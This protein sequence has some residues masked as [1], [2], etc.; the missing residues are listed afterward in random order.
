MVY[1]RVQLAV[2]RTLA[3]QNCLEL[4]S[5]NNMRTI[6]ANRTWYLQQLALAAHKKKGAKAL[7]DALV[8]DETGTQTLMNAEYTIDDSNCYIRYG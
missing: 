8:I 7:H 1:T 2:L 3:L 4:A 5:S 6:A